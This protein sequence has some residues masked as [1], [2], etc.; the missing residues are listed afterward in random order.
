MLQSVPI[1]GGEAGIDR[2]VE[3]AQSLIGHP[4]WLIYYAHDVQ[5]TPT[6]WGCTPAQLE[7]VCEAVS[8]SGAR[9]M[10]VSEAMQAL[11]A[12]A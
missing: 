7:R 4:G 5:D 12:D 8:A 3:A 10:T 2:A 11:E 6:Q 9:V 1:D